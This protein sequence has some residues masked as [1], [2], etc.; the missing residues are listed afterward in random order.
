[1]TPHHLTE[2]LDNYKDLQ[3]I[4]AYASRLPLLSVFSLSFLVNTKACDVDL[5]IA[6]CRFLFGHSQNGHTQ[7]HTTKR[8]LAFFWD[9]C[10]Q[11]NSTPERQSDESLSLTVWF[12]ILLVG[13][14]LFA[15]PYLWLLASYSIL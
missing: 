8:V 14:D 1:M 10:D 4:G 2:R 13:D 9:C 3:S 5:S 6:T 12:G 11:R 7:P 15:F